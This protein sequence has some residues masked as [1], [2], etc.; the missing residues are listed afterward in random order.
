[1]RFLIA[2]IVPGLLVAG[3]SGDD[4]T[5]QPVPTATVT[6][7]TPT[8]TPKRMTQTPT[9]P[10]R[11]ATRPPTGPLRLTKGMTRPGTRLRFGQKA[12]VPIRQ[13]YSFTKTYTEG[14][15]GVVVQRIQRAPGSKIEGNFDA[16][17]KAL[18]KSHTAYYAKIVITNESGNAM[19]LIEPHFD[20]LR[21]GG[22]QPDLALIGGD[23][24]GCRGTSSPDSFDHK[25]AQ[26]VTC[27]VGASSPSRP[28]REIRYEDPPYGK[29]IQTWD[30]DPAPRFN[31]YY[32]LGAITW[33]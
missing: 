5:A 14:V 12:I 30:D 13:Y 3:C 16:K 9:N 8:P 25:G 28:I 21:S 20:A 32:D 10:T 1:M 2:V 22:R 29:E 33:R 17:S 31:Q 23:L 19:S 27:E 18:L 15:L 24:P 11:D 7:P 26:W 6:A 4:D